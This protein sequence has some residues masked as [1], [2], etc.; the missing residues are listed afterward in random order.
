MVPDYPFPAAVPK[1]VV[2]DAAFLAQDTGFKAVSFGYREWVLIRE[3]ITCPCF[4]LL[5]LPVSI[6][7]EALVHLLLG[8]GLSWPVPGKNLLATCSGSPVQTV[9]ALC[10]TPARHREAKSPRC[11]LLADFKASC[12]AENRVGL[13]AVCGRG[14]DTRGRA[15][16]RRRMP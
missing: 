3:R 1:G 15:V 5:T 14:Q 9:L 10:S 7:R 2:W 4:T 8:F 16:L 12:M 11:V 6:S 13:V